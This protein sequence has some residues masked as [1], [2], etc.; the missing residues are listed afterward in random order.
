MTTERFEDILEDN[1]RMMEAGVALE[2]CVARHPDH[3]DELRAQLAMVQQLRVARMPAQAEITARARARSQ[4]LAAVDQ[5]R[6]SRNGHE[7]A[8]LIP[9]LPFRLLGGGARR[10]ALVPYALPAALAFVLL[11]GAAL[12]VSATTGNGE[13]LSWL[14]SSSSQTRIELRGALGAIDADSLT[15]E[16]E[17]G[18]VEVAITPDTEF[19]DANDDPVTAAAFSVGD[20]VKVHAVRADDGS[21]IAREVEIEGADEIAE[22]ADDDGD[23]DNRGPGNADDDAADDNSGPGN[24]DD[25]AADDNSG[26]GNADDGPGDDNSGPG[27][28]DDD[29]ADDNS[30][31]GNADDG[32]GDD[33]T[34]PGNVDDGPGDD[35][36]GPGNADDGAG[37][38][39]GDGGGDGGGDDAGDDAGT[40]DDHDDGGDD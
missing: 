21:L 32:P 10:L 8:L 15:V 19:E 12:G 26:P 14:V 39:D 31:P 27:N 6:A 11:G 36:T 24:A 20:V 28:A 30:G 2:D 1:I 7:P 33:N 13:P 25:D 18:P 16:T 29:A 22:D 3:A 34:G 35:N 5:Q 40:P 4:L 37:G 23:D 9:T 17:T 38:H